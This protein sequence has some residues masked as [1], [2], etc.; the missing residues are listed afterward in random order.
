[1]GQILVDEDYLNELKYRAEHDMLTGVLNRYAGDASMRR[2]F[3][4]HIPGY[5]VLMDIDLFK[6]F[7]DTYG[8]DTGD[9]VLK[10]IAQC[11]VA[12]IGDRVVRVGGDEFGFFIRKDELHEDLQAIFDRIFKR[13]DD[14]QGLDIE[15]GKLAISAGAAFYDG[16]ANDGFTSLYHKADR[17]CYQSKATVG[18]KVTID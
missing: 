11:L 1:M 4:E 16:N 15:D 7:N 6:Q 5:L 18:N 3:V 8:H 12:E 9:R 10:A 17:L 14:I 2:V 13:I